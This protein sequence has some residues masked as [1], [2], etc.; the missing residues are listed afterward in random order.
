MQPREKLLTRRLVDA[1]GQSK[2]RVGAVRRDTQGSEGWLTQLGAELEGGGHT[3]YTAPPQKLARFLTERVPAS[4]FMRNGTRNGYGVFLELGRVPANVAEPTPLPAILVAMDPE[5]F[6]SM[7]RARKA[8][9]RG[10][11]RR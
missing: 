5:R 11:V 7:S 3:D 1:S 2:A 9:R 6:P 8:C 4:S 10:T